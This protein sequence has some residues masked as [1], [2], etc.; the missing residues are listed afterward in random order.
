PPT[1]SHPEVPATMRPAAM[2]SHSATDQAVQNQ[3]AV[4]KAMRWLK[5][6]G[7][8]TFPDPVVRLFAQSFGFDPGPGSDWDETIA[9]L[10][11]PD[12]ELVRSAVRADARARLEST[13]RWFFERQI[14]R[15]RRNRP[16]TINVLVPMNVFNIALVDS[17]YQQAAKSLERSA[18]YVIERLKGL[19]QIA[20]E[21]LILLGDSYLSSQ[22]GDERA[23]SARAVKCYA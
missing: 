6:A 16:A 9:M 1:P 22:R 4:L 10:S 12:R 11:H 13:P 23:S 19:G 5:D 14:V 8:L 18:E 20:I 15:A 21:T 17:T 7:V 3:R 2:A